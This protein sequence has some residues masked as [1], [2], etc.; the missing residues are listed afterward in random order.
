MSV[1]RTDINR[2]YEDRMYHPYS[3]EYYNRSSFFNFGYWLED[4]QNQH[5]ACE[6]LM[7]RLLAFLPEKEG[8]I[9]DVACGKGA[10]TQYLT[11]YYSPEQI[12]GIDLSLK[13]LT[14]CRSNVPG[15]PFSLMSAPQLAFEDHSFE[16]M[17]CVEAVFHFDTR[18]DFL[19]EAHRVLKPGGRLILT[20][21]LMT[22][23]A[24]QARHVRTVKNYVPDLAA[25][26]SLYRRAGFTDVE[27]VDVSL[28]SWKR[29]YRHMFWW[30]WQEVLLKHHDLRTFLLFIPTVLAG[31]S[32]VKH[33]L[34]VSATKA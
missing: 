27:I 29:F 6:N 24:D 21:I 4:T 22:K 19:K 12:A 20:D 31:M 8:R 33:Y 11:R 30:H 34:L 9:L 5:E 32:A 26:R 25:Y 17:I 10:T 16:N 28:E 15:A 18:E 2:W 23:W 3:L 1:T 14:T 7:E 13:Q